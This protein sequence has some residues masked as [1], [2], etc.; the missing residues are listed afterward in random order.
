MLK[1]EH[2]SATTLVMDL[3]IQWHQNESLSWI[4][5]MQRLGGKEDSK[6]MHECKSIRQL[7][8]CPAHHSSA[9]VYRVHWFRAKARYDRWNEEFTLVPLE[10]EWMVSY[11]KKQAE[12][13]AVRQAQC[14][15][16][17]PICYAIWQASMWADF[18]SQASQAFQKLRSRPM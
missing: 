3:S 10:M 17:G 2:L 15:E 8:V 11:F 12:I 16:P 4:W 6:W 18:A 1:K 14:A 13:W 5:R 7:S 9:T